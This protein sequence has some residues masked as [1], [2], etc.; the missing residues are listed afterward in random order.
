MGNIKGVN[1]RRSREASFQK[2]PDSDTL[3]ENTHFKRQ[4]CAVTKMQQ[5]S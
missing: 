1:L 2:L 5:P 3:G 4:Y